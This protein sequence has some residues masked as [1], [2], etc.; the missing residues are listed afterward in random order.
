MNFHSSP[1]PSPRPPPSS[2]RSPSRISALTPIHRRPPPPPTSIASRS[3]FGRIGRLAF[4]LAYDNPALEFVH[5]NEHP[6]AG[7][8]SAYLAKYDSGASHLTLVPIRPRSR[9]ELH[10][11]RT[12]SPGARVSPPRVPRFQ[13]RRASTPFNSS[14]SD[15]AFRLRPDVA[16]NDGPSTLSPRALD[17]R[18]R[19]R[20]GQERHRRG[21]DARDLVLRARRA[22]GRAVGG[23]RRRARAG[24]LG[25]V[26]DAREAGAVFRARWV[27]SIPSSHR[28]PYIRPRS[29]ARWTPFLK[30]GL[31][32]ALCEPHALTRGIDIHQSKVRIPD[33]WIPSTN[34]T[35]ASQASKKCSSPRP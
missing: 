14:A 8:S 34:N 22:G 6:G 17:A 19:V 25:G 28:S 27:F 2:T 4:R 32:L 3:G 23:A 13:S 21:R 12:F 26:S 7:E 20:R 1:A 18:L 9:C 11:L 10:S 35:I 30:D 5:I 15:A 24:V 16:L 31:S 29:F 33:A